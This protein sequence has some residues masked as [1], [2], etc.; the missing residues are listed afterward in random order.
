MPALAIGLGVG[1]L[2][3][4]MY[5]A[6]KTAS[7]NTNTNNTNW[8]K[9]Q[10]VNKQNYEAQKEFYQNSIQWRKQDALNAGINPIY[11]LGASSA[12][13]SP[14]FQAS[15]DNAL[16]DPTADNINNAIAMGIS[17]YQATQQAKESK[18]QIALMKSQELTQQAQTRFLD[19]RTSELLSSVAEKAEQPATTPATTPAQ[20]QT[21][22]EQ[23]FKNE[24]GKQFVLGKW[25]DIP[26]T[27][28]KMQYLTPDSVIIGF[29]DKDLQ[30]AFADGS[31][32]SGGLIEGVEQA[33]LESFGIHA[34]TDI[35]T[36]QKDIKHG[37]FVLRTTQK[38]PG[39]YFSRDKNYEKKIKQEKTHKKYKETQEPAGIPDYTQRF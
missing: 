32:E 34:V 36:A 9:Q 8:Y 17:A 10:L 33:L 35:K 30:Q 7:N 24:L 31:M 14:S 1:T 4:G 3:A 20:I 5:S 27:A 23:T 25:Y 15:F 11:A 37:Y 12:N 13:F 39:W 19:A 38:M 22:K 21:P 28:Y 6:N 18:A 29:K 2:L 16:K 26:N